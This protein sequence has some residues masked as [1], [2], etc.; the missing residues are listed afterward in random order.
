MR[1]TT[2]VMTP[3]ER[4][5]LY[6]PHRPESDCWLWT[7]P[8]CANGYGEFRWNDGVERRRVG[9]HVAAFRLLV[10]PV[11]A[12][13]QVNHQCDVRQCCNPGHLYVGDQ[14]Q[15]MRDMSERSRGS[16]AKAKVTVGQ[17][18]EIRALRGLTNS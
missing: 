11:P 1:K 4:L 17:V 15:N 6:V 10:G 9:A 7:G 18:R 16:R 14:A 13:G 12:G 2:K 3:E 8:M 5:E